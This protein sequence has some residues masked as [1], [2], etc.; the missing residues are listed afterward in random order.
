MKIE[1]KGCA[2]TLLHEKALYKHEGQILI[3]ADVHLGK[4]RHFRKAGIAIPTISQQGDYT[5]LERL[6]RKTNPSEVYFLGDLFHSTVNHDWQH[7]CELIA[8]F[9]SIKF[10]LIRGNHDLIH[11]RQFGQICVEVV[12]EIVNGDFIYTH[13]PLEPVP[14]GKINIAGH[15]H[16]GFVLSGGA[17]ESIKL[18]CFYATPEHIILP[19]FGVLTGL[20][21]MS[22]TAE[23]KIY[24][25]L[26]DCI[27]AIG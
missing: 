22:K 2:F 18:P 9:P 20:Y 23:V 24:A 13:E 10:T 5:N 11:N 17:R 15:I 3:I 4:A 27:K 1:I 14:D 12:D 25:V 7:F 19:A 16:P 26:P 6:F 21:S 8:L